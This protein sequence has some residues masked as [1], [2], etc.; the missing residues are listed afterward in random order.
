MDLQSISPGRTTPSKPVR[1]SRVAGRRVSRKLRAKFRGLRAEPNVVWYDAAAPRPTT[2]RFWK[3]TPSSLRLMS[4]SSSLD[5]RKMQRISQGARAAATA[6]KNRNAHALLDHIA[7]RLLEVER[8]GL[9]GERGVRGDGATVLL[10][11]VDV[12]LGP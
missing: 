7:E 6:A 3:L 8:A 10:V 9:G 4:D 2:R 11:G 1:M 12:E 5:G